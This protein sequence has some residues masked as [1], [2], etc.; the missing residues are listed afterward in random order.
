MLYGDMMVVMIR[1]PWHCCARL[2]VAA[3][4]NGDV[5]G[6]AL[7]HLVVEHRLGAFIGMHVAKQLHA[8][9]SSSSNDRRLGIDKPDSRMSC[10]AVP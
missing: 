8:Q 1:A 4:P 5:H 7:V 10:T 2:N 6:P 9:Q 3:I